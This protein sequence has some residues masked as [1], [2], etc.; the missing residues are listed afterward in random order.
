MRRRRYVAGIALAAAAPLAGCSGNGNGAATV[1]NQSAVYREALV[2]AVEDDG[3]VVRDVTVDGRVALTYSPAEGTRDGVEASIRDVSR[4]FF[5]RVYGGWT[6]EGLDA[7]VRIDGTLVATWRM[8][9]RWI[10]S[11]LAGDIT[12]D[13]LG[14]RVEESVERHGPAVT[15]TE[16]EG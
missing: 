13:E 5:D 12:R 3:H 9:R 1:T 8:E 14:Q 11:Y 15:V 16:T 7:R 4:A 6:V 10:E 2:N